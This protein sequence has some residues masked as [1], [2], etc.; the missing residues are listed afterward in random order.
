MKPDW[1]E[2]AMTAHLSSWPTKTFSV[3]NRKPPQGRNIYAEDRDEIHKAARDH[4]Y[5]LIS[6]AGE[7]VMTFKRD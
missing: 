7:A 2:V 3:Q 5:R 6:G 4:G 1:N